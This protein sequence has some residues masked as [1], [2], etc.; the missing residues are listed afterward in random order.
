MISATSVVQSLLSGMAEGVNYSL[1]CLGLAF[2]F[3]IVRI[4]NLAH[5]EF[6]VLGGYIAY[7]LL[8]KWGVNPLLALPLAAAMAGVAA[9]VSYRVFLQRIR[10]SSELN[11]LILTFGLGIFLAN[12]Y[13]QLWTADIRNIGVDWMEQPLSFFGIYVSVGEIL[14]ILIS[15]AVVFGLYFFLTRSRTGMAIRVTAIDRDAAAL[16]G[17]NVE[18]VDLVAFTIGGLLAG[19]GG[20][21][22]GMLAHISPGAGLHITVKAFILTVLAGVGSI[23]GLLVAGMILGVGEALTVT[24]I[25]ASYREL[26]GFALFI[27]IL[28]IRPSGL[29]GRRL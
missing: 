29:F 13:L 26:F 24:F 1:Y 12:L 23:P 20:P 6:L 4:I 21:L 9:F 27:A 10:T 17:I 15:L 8:V 22:L 5:G 2:V 28:V 19:V 25:N 18:R 7:W 14:T 11:T 16:A 3:G